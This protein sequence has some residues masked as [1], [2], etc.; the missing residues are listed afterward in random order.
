MKFAI[1]ITTK[2]RLQDLIFTLQKSSFLLANPD[3]EC[4]IC[5]D[6]STDGTFEYLKLNYPNII[7]IQNE[8]SKGLI[9]SRNRL[10]E[11][12]T[13]DYAISLDDDAN[14]LT[15]NILE[16][17]QNYF[18]ENPNCALVSFRVFWNLIN[19]KTLISN[20]Q[21]QRVKSFVGCGHCW[22]VSD[23]K[24]IPEYP[25][26]FIFYGE[27]D[28][29]AFQLFKLNKEVHYLPS[30]L[31]HHRVDVASRKK[32]NDY[33]VRT[34]RS[35]RSGWYLYFLFYPWR[36]IPGRLFF[37]FWKQIKSKTFKGDFKATVG[38]FQA[39]L[40]VLYNLPKLLQNSNRLTPEEFN[41]FFKIPEVKLYWKPEDEK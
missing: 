8:I 25:E 35:F 24:S 19:P 33:I 11:K 23:W 16:I 34:R 41:I 26:W 6:G 7:L 30:V 32:D 5:D 15:D 27:E 9:Y 20:Q 13:A 22:R 39:F 18:N 37:T 31:V 40:D 21:A 4:I 28:F 29:A 10:L 3:V 38:I 14:F 2:N 36:I 17:T 1:L 12:T